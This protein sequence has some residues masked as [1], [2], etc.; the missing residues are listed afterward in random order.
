[1]SH[2]TAQPTTEDILSRKGARTAKDI[3]KHVLQL[4]QAGQIESVNLTEWLAVDHLLLFQQI[5]VEWKLHNESH[6]IIEQLAP[7]KEHRIMKIIPAIASGWLQIMDNQ[8]L[9]GRSS[10]FSV[11]A[12]HQ[13]DGVRCWAAY[14]IGLDSRLNLAEK[15][16]RIT[17]FAADHHFGVREIAWMAVRSPVTA[18]LSEAL[19]LLAHWAT[20]PDPLIRRFAIEVI[21]PHRVWSKHIQQLKEQPEL[22]LPLLELVKSDTVKY[23]QD[24][25]SNWLNDASKSNPDWVRRICNNWAEQSDTKHTRRII[26]RAQR[27]L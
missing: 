14:I 10:L 6:E 2:K 19:E 27:S 26:T 21:R 17:P 20:H 12:E 16:E 11:L 18:E 13:S 4:L 9:H 22:A 1:M 7:M 25:V 15:L 3:P 24:S 23:V 8:E 5:I